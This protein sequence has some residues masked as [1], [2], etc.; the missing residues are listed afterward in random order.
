MSPDVTRL[1]RWLRR[2]QP[3]RGALLRAMVSG[4]VASLTNVGLFVGAIALLVVSAARPGLRAVAG[5]LIVIELLA[6]LRSP[7]RFNE[8]LSAHRLGF[9]A[10]TRW[11]RW[12]VN[13]IGRWDFSKWRSYASGDLLERSL[14]DTDELQDLWLRCVIPICSTLATVVLGDLVIGLLPPHTGWWTYAGLLALLQLLGLAGL[15]ANVGPLVR[16]DRELR[17]ARGWYRATL[18]ELSAVAPELT[19]LE[20]GAFLEERSRES[21]DSLRDAERT[22][23]RQ[24]RASQGV[25]LLVT[26]VGLGTLVARHPV[27]SPTWTVVV[28]LIALSSYDSLAAVRGALDTAVAVTAAAERLEDLESPARAGDQPWPGD[29]TMRAEN[30]TLREGDRVILANASFEVAP[31]RRVA[32]TGPSGSGKSTLLRAL[33]ALEPPEGG[34]LSV[35]GVQLAS[36]DE[37]ALRRHLAY[38]A[39][40]PG[41]ARGFALD[42]VRLGRASS[43]DT[44]SDLATLGLPATSSTKWD[45]LS[46]GERQ[47][48]AVARAMVPNPSICLLD[49]PTSGLGRAE[50]ETVLALLASEGA[51]VIVATHDPRVMAWCDEVLELR[52]QSLRVLSH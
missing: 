33:S 43:R 18:V 50:T 19:L 7:I 42:V 38:L 51:T 20:G 48:V 5:V 28:A 10:V 46:R 17:Q 32:I 41:L 45:D 8:R 29:S 36:I 52:E 22:L 40:E 2:A 26:A 49:E 34:S 15:F 13:S 3:P 4:V 9:Q 35:G 47:R 24:R 6:F 12:L 16:A 14:R 44:L 25:A 21:R 27:S 37:G 39:S 23:R 31:G 11:R 1:L 30:L